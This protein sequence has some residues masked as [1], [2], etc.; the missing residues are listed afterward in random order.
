MPDDD[1][2][3][4]HQALVAVRDFGRGDDLPREKTRGLD[5][6]KQGET[7]GDHDEAA[8]QDAPIFK[9]FFV[10]EAIELRAHVRDAQVVAQGR[11]HVAEVFGAGD[12]GQ[13]RAAGDD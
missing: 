4:G 6:E 9:F 11:H 10:V 2:Q 13:R 8:E 12:H 3:E 1:H 7:R 5:G